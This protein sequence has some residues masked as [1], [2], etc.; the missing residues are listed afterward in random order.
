[1]INAG[2]SALLENPENPQFLS[3]AQHVTACYPVVANNTHAYVTLHSTNFCGNNT[4][5]LQVYDTSAL[6]NPVLIHQRNLIFPRGLGLYNDYLFICDDVIKIFSIQNPAEPILVGS[7]Q[8]NCFDVI[9]NGNKLYAIGQNGLYLYE[10]NPQDIENYVLKSS[11][12]F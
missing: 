5:V 7:I 3:N 10:L 9:I 4:N 2:R 6:T 8:L 12:S 1:M 11:I